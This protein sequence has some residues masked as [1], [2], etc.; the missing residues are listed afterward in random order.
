ML[1]RQLMVH[2]FI[3][4]ELNQNIW[5][6]ARWDQAAQELLTLNQSGSAYEELFK[7]FD[8]ST[9]FHLAKYVANNGHLAYVAFELLAYYNE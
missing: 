3:Y 2:S 4:Y 7:D 6:D 9:G 1:Q 8:G 5:S